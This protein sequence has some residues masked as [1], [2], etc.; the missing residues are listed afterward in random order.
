MKAASVPSLIAGLS[1]GSVL[2]VGAYYTSQTPPKPLLQL[3]CSIV[4]GLLMGYRFYNSNKIMPAGVVSIL[5]RKYR[6]HFFR[7]FMC[8]AVI[9]FILV[10]VILRTFILWNKYLPLIGAKTE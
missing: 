8:Y 4:L 3:V 6:L 9:Y 7:M 5:S 10:I 1:F 2:A